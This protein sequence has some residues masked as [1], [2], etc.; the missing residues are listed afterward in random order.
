MEIAVVGGAGTFGTLVTAELERRGHTVRV[1]SRSAPQY[2]VDLRTGAGLPQALEG[3]EVVVDSSNDAKGD[4]Q[5]LA[6]GTR[7]LLAAEAQA[8]VAHHVLIS[9][10]G[11]DRAPF[12]Y[13]GAK[14]EQ[15]QVVRKS[16]HPW[17]ILR[18]TQFHQLLDQAFGSLAGY[19]ISPR[20]RIELQPVDPREVA[21][22]MADAIAQGPWGA[23]L[24]VAGPE[25]MTMSELA[26]IWSR[27]TGRRR[28][29][30]PLPVFGKPA[31]AAR[32]GALTAP[33]AAGK[34][35][36]AEWLGERGRRAPSTP[37]LATAT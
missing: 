13:L 7:R 32:A 15:E 37:N 34:L 30:M 26:R 10:V 22:A 6:E 9:I 11:I 12:K 17:S 31:S 1:L 16:A 36:F 29:P 28:M 20:S 18:A 23:G 3:V 14:L 5:V 21:T 25:V 27:S 35:G 2:K 4:P 8:Q 24:E 19:G 33:A